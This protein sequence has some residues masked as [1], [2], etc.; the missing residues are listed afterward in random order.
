MKL[1]AVALA[2]LAVAGCSKKQDSPSVGAGQGGVPGPQDQ[3][4][5]PSQGTLPELLA[6]TSA[7][8]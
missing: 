4:A 8:H 6:R 5:R 2:I 1:V 7:P 3:A